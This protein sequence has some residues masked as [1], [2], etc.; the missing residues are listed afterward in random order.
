MTS[1]VERELL[2]APDVICRAA[3]GVAGEPE[4]RWMLS[5]PR[6]VRRS[7][8]HDVIDVG[9][10]EAAQRRWM[11]QAPDE[12]RESYVERVLSK[13]AD[14]PT[15][16]VLWMLGSPEAVRTSYVE[17]VLEADE[18]VY[19]PD[20][21]WMLRQPD[22]V[23]ESYIEA[24]NPPSAGRRVLTQP[25]PR[26]ASTTRLAASSTTWSTRSSQSSSAVH[27]LIRPLI[28]PTSATDASA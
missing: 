18:D 4:Q 10:D 15:P 11:L 3:A 5:Q 27:V 7:Y 28:A 23:R 9:E 12:V 19:R 14:G 21:I 2:L 25:R 24:G 8:V 26:S 13:E 22:S 17:Q 6:Q 16:E 20:V 1:K